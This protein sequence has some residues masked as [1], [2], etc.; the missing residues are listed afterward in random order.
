MRLYGSLFTEAHPEANG[1]DFLKN[2]N[3]NSL[4]VVTVYV[5]PSLA[6][7]ATGQ[8]FQFERY[9]YFVTD[10]VDHT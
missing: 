2:L 5:E 7:V 9:G 1:K 4:S 6:N 10:L 3:A 8:R